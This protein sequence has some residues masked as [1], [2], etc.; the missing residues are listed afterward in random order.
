MIERIELRSFGFLRR[1]QAVPLP[2]A[3]RR[4]QDASRLL[5]STGELVRLQLESLDLA[6][7][8]LGEPARVSRAERARLPELQKRIG[9]EL[10]EQQALARALDI[11]E[12][13]GP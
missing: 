3:P 13:V 6:G 8:L 12:C 9:A 7:A 5:E 4:R 2:S 1:F 10:R 11:P